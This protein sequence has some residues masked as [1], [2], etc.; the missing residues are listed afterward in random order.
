MNRRKRKHTIIF[1]FRDLK[2]IAVCLSPIIIDY[3]VFSTKFCII[4]L[5]FHITFTFYHLLLCKC[6]RYSKPEY[7]SFKFCERYYIAYACNMYNINI[8]MRPETCVFKLCVNVL[9]IDLKA[10][11]MGWNVFCS[12]RINQY[13]RA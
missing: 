5:R 2:T 7:I 8:S 13:Y 9:S 3:R 11:S 6:S 1:Q 10:L 12:F 4:C